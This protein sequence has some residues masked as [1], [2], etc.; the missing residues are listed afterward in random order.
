MYLV[1]WE[2]FTGGVCL[3]L[4]CLDIIYQLVCVCVCVECMFVC[5][6]S[7][8]LCVCGVYV[9]VCVWGGGGYTKA[10]QNR[11]RTNTYPVRGLMIVLSEM[12]WSSCLIPRWGNP[13]MGTRLV[14]RISASDE[15]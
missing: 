8:C 11:I 10:S 2:T 6:W 1:C 12:N 13:V 15:C 9:C 5:V 14:P 7:V 3:F 4:G